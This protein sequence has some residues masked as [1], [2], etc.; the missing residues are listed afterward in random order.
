MQLTWNIP[1]DKKHLQIM[2]KDDLLR[3]EP[4]LSQCLQLMGLDEPIRFCKVLQYQQTLSGT[5]V[6]PKKDHPISDQIKFAFL[7]E[8]ETLYIIGNPAKLNPWIEGFLQEYDL[9]VASPYEFLLR[10]L[11]YMIKEDVYFLEEYNEE[12]Q[13]IETDIFEGKSAGMERFSMNSRKDMNLLENYYQQLCA[14]GSTLQQVILVHPGDDESALL[15]LFLSRTSQLLNLVGEIKDYDSQIW[16]LRQTQLS[17]KQNKIS[18]LL[19]IISTI[20]LPLTFLTGWYGMN[21]P[22]MPLLKYRYGYV[23]IICVV[24]LILVLEIG[25]IK[26]HHWLDL[27]RDFDTVRRKSKSNKAKKD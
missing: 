14:V 18:T 24:A 9:Q 13:T 2:T 5:F 17:D 23:V 19:T 11:N 27:S 21:F 12:M 16:N 4:Q 22:H 7:L 20:F 8:N 15:S 26:S 1:P 6:I 10:L 25:Y 3:I